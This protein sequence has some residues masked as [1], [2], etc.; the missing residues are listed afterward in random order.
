M[1]NE[2]HPVRVAK[3]LRLKEE[4]GINAYPA[5]CDES[6]SI[7]EIR[8]AGETEDSVTAS[9]RLTGK[10]EH[11][12][13]VFAD[14]RDGTGSI[15]LY[16]GKKIL[17]ERDWS[18]L[19]LLDLGDIIQIKGTVFTTRT[20]ELTVKCE[21]VRLLC[22]SLR[23]L[24]VV[25]VDAD[26]TVHDEVTD[27]DF[28]FRHR[29]VDLQV[30]PESLD[31]FIKRSRIV[32]ALRSYLD[33]LGFLEVETPVL[34]P[35]YGGAAAEPFETRY[36]SMNRQFYLRIATEL[37]LKRLVAGGIDKVY[38]LGKDFR[39]EGI[40]RTHSPEFTQLELYE[41]YADYT[42][43]MN[44]FEEMSVS[45][46]AAADHG[47]SFEYQG[48]VIDFTPP[49]RRIGF[50]DSLRE[51][52]REDLF[53]WETEDLKELIIRN[54]INT[55]A[56]DRTT[57]LDKLFDFYVA[58]RIVQPTFVVDYPEE[59]SPLAKRKEDGS[60]VTERFEVFLAGLEL[61]NAFSEQNDPVLQR[62][63]L[64]AQA[65]AG[66]HRKGKPD[67]DFLYALETG[68]PPTGGMGIGVDRLVMVLTDTS[69]IRD[70]ILFPHLRRTGQ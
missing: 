18:V 43:M 38:E 23:Q 46:A 1:T 4:L 9:G 37:Y 66:K 64:K 32:S 5:R 19:D 3:L 7:L 67:E 6:K 16:L 48:T 36:G 35:L 69:R 47:R 28:L 2:K 60:G 14:L 54:G 13:T 61:A 70:T 59:L 21:E 65:D 12:K 62:K 15:Q 22:K 55:Q 30:N 68:M 58:N 50:L 11:G 52:S 29:C 20:G 49:F 56:D 33:S 57:M 34:Q 26:G 40:D 8:D 41:A 31:R 45:A 42:T 53:S 24:P 27:R 17:T 10:R 39:N 25:K 51:A 63:I 44:R